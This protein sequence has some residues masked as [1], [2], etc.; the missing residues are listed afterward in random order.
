[1]F[2]ESKRDEIDILEIVRQLIARDSC[3]SF[4][5][6]E[7]CNGNGE[8]KDDTTGPHC[9]CDSGYEGTY[10]QTREYYRTTF[11]LSVY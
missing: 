2:L 11:A 1:M 6:T 9:V 3:F 8:C 5:A 4:M 10:C 7:G